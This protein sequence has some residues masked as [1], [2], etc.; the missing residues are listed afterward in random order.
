MFDNLD[1]F[2]DRACLIKADGPVLTYGDVIDRA[3]ALY[4]GASCRLVFVYGDG[5]VDTLLAYIGAVRAGV[6]VHILNPAKQED[7][8]RLIELYSPDILV[9]SGERL[10]PSRH[11][12]SSAIHPDLAILLSTS[13]ST[14][15]PKL[16]KLSREN[17]ASN[18]RSII[19]Y[20]DLKPSDR[21]VTSLSAFY[22]YGLSVINT[23]L[24]AGASLLV[25]DTV[26]EDPGFWT[27]LRA[28]AVTNLAGVPY[29]FERLAQKKPEWTN[30]P[31]LRFLTQAGGKLSPDLVRHFAQLGERKGF[32]FFVMYGQTEAAPRMAY[33]P[34]HKAIQSPGAIGVAVPGGRLWLEDPE[35]AAVEEPGMEGELIYAGANVMAGY[36]RDRSDLETLDPQDSLRT[37]DMATFDAQGLFTIT[38]RASRFVKPFGL[39]VSLDDI[40]NW[41][42]EGQG[43]AA[44]IGD[45]ESVVIALT[46]PSTDTIAWKEAITQKCGLPADFLRVERVE[47][48]PRLASGK[49]DYA[50]LKAVLME[51]AQ[52]T[53]SQ[54]GLLR[55]VA[56]EFWA[57]LT[58]NSARPESVMA[59]YKAVLGGA[60]QDE[61]SSFN[62]AGGDSLNMVQLQLAL[63]EYGGHLPDGWPD[64]SIRELERRIGA[65]NV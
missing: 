1:R 5:D 40:E 52:D 12:S 23:H 25:T 24:E 33:L 9:R 53:L 14:G 32:E 13:G 63:E 34:P 16:V 42:S 48:I 19:Q 38:G 57:I 50:A 37:G 30:W 35:G 62:S 58:G 36:A 43:E 45:D 8:A 29:H 47:V 15:S 65:I 18:T 26:F 6:A 59:A 20:L 54:P 11:K 21:G 51:R 56:A 28:N 55:E 22:S 61:D 17:I 4:R 44:V 46:D 60:V 10:D 7:N 2:S 27:Q 41:A 31:Q 39:R 49:I 64:L 3:D